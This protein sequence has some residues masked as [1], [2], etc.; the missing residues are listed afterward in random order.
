MSD[1]IAVKEE[2]SCD[3]ASLQDAAFTF[4]NLLGKS[5]DRV[6][7]LDSPSPRPKRARTDEEVADHSSSLPAA[8]V[9]AAF[10]EDSEHQFPLAGAA[11]ADD[12]EA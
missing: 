4:H 10:Q 1:F 7:D 6:I 2:I 5:S 9:Q 8:C 12:V 11:D 3:A